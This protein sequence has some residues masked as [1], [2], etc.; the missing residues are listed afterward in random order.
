[1]R[2]GAS[3]DDVG[4]DERQPLEAEYDLTWRG[5]IDT[6]HRYMCNDEVNVLDDAGRV[7]RRERRGAELSALIVGIVPDSAP[8]VRWTFSAFTSELERHN[9]DD[10]V[11]PEAANVLEAASRDETL[12]R[13][14]I[15]L[16]GVPEANDNYFVDL[17]SIGLAPKSLSAAGL[18][19]LVAHTRVFWLIATRRHGGIDRLR[20]LGDSTRMPW[21]GTAEYAQPGEYS[22]AAVHRAENILRFDGLTV[23]HGREAALLT[24][25]TPYDPSVPGWG[26]AHTDSLGQLWIDLAAGELLAAEVT[27]ISCAA[28]VPK[29]NGGCMP[30]NLRFETSLELLCD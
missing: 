15:I 2:S 28:G 24:Y 8:I 13:G 3:K 25:R 12:P 21:S 5:T 23:R 19:W 26:P 20:A 29:D 11:L 22:G 27:S 10:L 30:L 9:F 14:P 18:G 16:E 4:D 7:V 1:M 6:K 17:G